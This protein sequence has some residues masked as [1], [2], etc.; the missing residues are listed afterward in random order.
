M[1]TATAPVALKDATD[2]ARGGP[3]APTTDRR[4]PPRRKRARPYVILAAVVAAGL[5]ALAITRA[6]TAG[7]ESTDDATVAA[8]MVPI[9][10]RVGGLVIAVPVTDNQT[11]K[12]GDLLAKI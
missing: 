8:D 9:A 3:A 6:V 5:V 7:R 4:P 11:V 1:S 10:A 2:A 12:A